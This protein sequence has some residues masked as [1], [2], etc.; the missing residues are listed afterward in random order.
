[1]TTDEETQVRLKE[2][3]ILRILGLSTKGQEVQISKKVQSS[4][5]NRKVD[6][7]GQE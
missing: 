4:D 3:I 6:P 1:M 7:S 5:Q 2:A